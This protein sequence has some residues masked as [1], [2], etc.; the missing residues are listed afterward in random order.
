[1]ILTDKDLQLLS[2]IPSSVPDQEK[3]END[4]K[5]EF[6]GTT[7]LCRV[8]G[9]KASGFHYGVHSCEGCKG[10]FRRSIQQKIQYR[11]CT[12][13]QQCSI[14]RINRNRCQYCRLKKCIAVGM[15]R[16]AVRFGRVP[17]REKAKILAAMQKVN[18]SSQEKALGAELEDEL[19]LLTTIVRAHEETCD[20]TK[21]K[22]IGLVEKAR[23]Q[24]VYTQCPPQL[25]CPLNPAPH[26]M[27]NGASHYMEDFSERFAP[28]IKGVVEFAKRIPGFGFLSQDD[29]VTLLKA[30]VFEVLLVRL[31]CMFDSHANSLICLNG[32]VLRRESLHSASNARFLL[33][34]MFDF[35]E[36]LNTLHLS[37][38]EVGLFCAVVV[39][40][41]D[42][43]GLRNTDLVCKVQQ[44]M[45][46]IL[47][48]AV[49]ANH[50]ENPNIFGDLMKKIPDLRT[51]NTLHSEKLL[52][53]KMEPCNRRAA[54]AIDG[55]TDTSMNNQTAYT[56]IPHDIWST[57]SLV[58][59]HPPCLAPEEDLRS[60]SPGQH[61][62][63][64]GST[65]GS[66]WSTTDSKDE[67]DLVGSPRSIGSG[68]CV[69][70][71]KS[72]IRTSSFS[73]SRSYANEETWQSEANQTVVDY[74]HS[75]PKRPLE[76]PGS[77]HGSSSGD[78]GYFIDSPIKG[79]VYPKLRRVDSPTDSGIESG[80]E[81]GPSTTPTI[82]VC[83]S[84][85]SSVD[86]KVKDMDHDNASEKHDTIEDM[87]V[88]KR[89]LQAPPI[90]NPHMLMD[91]AYRHHKK[92][93]A[94]RREAESP[95]SPS[96]VSLASTHS[97]LVRTLEQAPRYLSEQQLKRTDLIHNIIMQKETLPGQQ[98]PSQP[99]HQQTHQQ[100]LS[101]SHH[102]DTQSYSCPSMQNNHYP[103]SSVPNPSGSSPA[104][105]FASSNGQTHKNLLVCPNG[106]YMPQGGNVQQT[107][108][109]SPATS[110]SWQFTQQSS[111]AATVTSASPVQV[112][113]QY[114]HSSHMPQNSPGSH[115]NSTSNYCSSPVANT[116]RAGS[117]R[118]LYNPRSSPPATTS[119]LVMNGNGLCSS[120]IQTVCQADMRPGQTEA[121]YKPSG[122]SQPLNL[123]KKLFSPPPMLKI[124]S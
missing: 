2:S 117:P 77:E 97:T 22:V 110:V 123:S 121:S 114:E 52:A 20:Y 69:D 78:E 24:P 124:E 8:C 43:P 33:D 15:S 66:E 102:A 51:L 81:H 84:P 54:G 90:I 1:M 86:E 53:Y 89:A 105:T 29:Q 96:Q 38:S 28:A 82:S 35:A 26:I 45:K 103:F 56:A 49:S 27:E 47:E 37:D 55:I 65:T 122:E 91:E 85:R 92:F 71:V 34:S 72:P 13:N 75:M 58:A 111:S 116:S 12:K 30:G 98:Q 88:L 63:H 10:F 4:L 74:H 68:L 112:H 50:P 14:L 108:I 83:S 25:A 106:Y 119:P 76:N 101:Q 19:R 36:R 95:A 57:Y 70:D 39:I 3:R 115:Q 87:P 99:Q 93:R 118:L 107:S 44:K 46:N 11:P 73:S 64:G 109:Y 17:K 94:A 5:I 113:A 62:Q 104:S 16:D 80:K 59:A 79:H 6:D 21:D 41:S 23:N 60:T 42:R 9:D 40:A 67:H 18:A 31:A 48:K 32:Q 100:T 7:V 61:S 120:T